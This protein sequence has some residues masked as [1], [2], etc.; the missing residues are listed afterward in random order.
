MAVKKPTISLRVYKGSEVYYDKEGNVINE[1][2][3]ITLEH[4]T[5]SWR[6]F[7][8]H[9]TR[10]GYALVEVERAYFSELKD[11]EEKIEEVKELKSFQNEVEKAFN[12]AD[13][14]VLTPEQLRIQ[15]LEAKNA[16][17]QEKLDSLITSKVEGATKPP[18]KLTTEKTKIQLLRA[19]YYELA[20]KRCAPSWDEST[21]ELKINELKA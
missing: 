10:H 15:E 4:N 14:V 7:L 19:E 6:L 20:G 16:E 11:G 3:I 17:F 2:Q 13:D 12:P 18:K 21:L 5:L 8:Q 1:N 9:I